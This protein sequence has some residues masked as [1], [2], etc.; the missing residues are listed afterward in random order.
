MLPEVV[1]LEY[2]TKMEEGQYL[3]RKSAKIKPIDIARHL[4][5]FANANGGILVIGIEDT[6]EITG[7]KYSGAK[8][9]NDFVNVPFT[10]CSGNLKIS[11]EERKV[12]IGDRED[13]ILVFFIDPSDNIVIKTSDEKVYLRI[14]DKSKLLKS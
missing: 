7:F 8:S 5:A 3:D 2:L 14:G 4:V 1:T 6:G 11:Y 12:K 10:A 13:S 9:I